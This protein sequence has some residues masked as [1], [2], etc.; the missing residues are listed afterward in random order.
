MPNQSETST[1][2]PEK[3]WIGYLWIWC[4]N[5]PRLMREG[6]FWSVNN[7]LHDEGCLL[8]ETRRE[9]TALGSSYRRHWSLLDWHPDQPAGAPQWEGSLVVSS[10]RINILANFQ[11]QDLTWENV[12]CASVHNDDRDSVYDYSALEEDS[13]YNCFYDNMP[14]K[15][16]WPWPREEGIVPKFPPLI[17]GKFFPLRAASHTQTEKSGHQESGNVNGCVIL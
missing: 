13:N 15:G 14:M 3:P 16:F 8:S 2:P 4:N 7:I 11:V 10:D 1:S 5:V 12:Y 17:P 6:F 9:F